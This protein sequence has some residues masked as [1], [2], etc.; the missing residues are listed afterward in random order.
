MATL[1]APPWLYRRIAQEREK[2]TASHRDRF[3]HFFLRIR[4]RENR[5]RI[6]RRGPGYRLT[7]CCRTAT[8]TGKGWEER[9]FL[10][11]PSSAGLAHHWGDRRLWYYHFDS[12]DCFMRLSLLV[13][14]QSNHRLIWSQLLSRN[15]RAWLCPKTQCASHIDNLLTS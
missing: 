13:Q 3:S 1:W 14:F 11:I 6:G 2:N 15:R 4:P 12:S 8:K 5:C 9:W 7:L 10:E